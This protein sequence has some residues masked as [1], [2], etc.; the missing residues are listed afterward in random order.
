VKLDASAFSFASAYTYS[1]IPTPTPTPTNTGFGSWITT[2]V[3]QRGVTTNT[4]QAAF[5]AAYY[6]AALTAGRALAIVQA[7][8][9]T[10]SNMMILQLTLAVVGILLNNTILGKGYDQACVAAVMFGYALSSIFP[11]A[12]TVVGDYNYTMDASAT[13]SFIIGSTVGDGAV[14]WLVGVVMG[15]YGPNALPISSL[16]SVVV[17]ICLYVFFQISVRYNLFPD[18]PNAT[19]AVK[20]A[21]EEVKPLVE[22]ELTTTTSSSGSETAV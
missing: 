2:Y 5:I 17:C 10:A 12:M 18:V 22:V 19:A 8:Y 7:I 14:P 15:H 6:W 13:A 16:I 4:E 1:P 11:L 9:M 3:L 21:V 20:G